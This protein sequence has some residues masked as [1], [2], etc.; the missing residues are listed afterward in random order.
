M[1]RIFHLDACFRH[2]FAG[3]A[4]VD[5]VLTLNRY[6]NGNHWMSISD[7]AQEAVTGWWVASGI[8]V[9]FL[10]RLSSST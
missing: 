9:L 1:G 2:C 4:N 5:L 10:L 8:R 3:C 6:G 7:P